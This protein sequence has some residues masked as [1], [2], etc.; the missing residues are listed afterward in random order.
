VSLVIFIM[1]RVS[2]DPRHIYLDD[3]STQEDWDR[4]GEVLGLDKPYYQQYG[5]FLKDALR[6]DLGESVREARPVIEV[7]WERLPATLM[8]GSVA[9]ALSLIIGVPLGILSAIRRG[10]FLDAFGKLVALIG[11]SAPPFWL[12][13]MLMFLF[14]VK[15]GWLP[16]YGKQDWNSI[17]LPA[18]TLGWYYAAANLRLVRSAMLDVLDS[19]Y[20]KLAR[21]KGVNSKSVILKHAFRNALIPPLTFAGVTLGALVTGSLVVETV[22]AWPGLGRLAIEAL[23]AFDYPLLQGV[24]ITFT[25]L[26]VSAAFIVD[27]M[28]AYVDPR[29]RY[30]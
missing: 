8:L 3:Y 16:P 10:T 2:G 25:L 30:A 11:Q 12:G 22:F 5:L 28:Y 29:I 7:V 26:Y 9:F 6:G 4:M 19:E 1:S 23:F 17:I 13:I 15:L 21:A 27:V 20:I 14:A 18:V 24:V